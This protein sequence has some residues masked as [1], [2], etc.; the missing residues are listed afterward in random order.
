VTVVAWALVILVLGL[1][2]AWFA[3]RRVQRIEP[4]EALAGGGTT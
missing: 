3:A 2:S 4:A 1:V